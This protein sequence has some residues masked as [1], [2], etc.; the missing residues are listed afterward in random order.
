MHGFDRLQNYFLLNEL[1]VDAIDA[2]F[3]NFQIQSKSIQ[4]KLIAFHRLNCT[5]S[6]GRKKP[7]PFN[8]TFDSKIA[9]SKLL[10]LFEH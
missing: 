5:F 9:F 2:I 10:Q 7:I 6:S 8:I 4:Q 3:F 1:F